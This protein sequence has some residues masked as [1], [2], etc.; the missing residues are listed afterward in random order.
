MYINH[1][2]I[3]FDEETAATTTITKIWLKISTCYVKY[4]INLL[5]CTC[6]KGVK[7]STKNQHTHE[8]K[9][10]KRSI[11]SKSDHCVQLGELV[12]SSLSSK[13]LFALFW[14]AK[15]KKKTISIEHRHGGT[16]TGTSNR[17]RYYELSQHHVWHLSKAF[18]R[19][20]WSVELMIVYLPFF[21]TRR[22]KQ[23]EHTK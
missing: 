9:I 10:V 17:I 21:Y 14:E 12:H 7:K 18:N 5:W 13:R 2:I 4:G 16:G 3:L 20:F 11:L 22:K 15:K 6:T 8:I 1:D 19:M 23:T